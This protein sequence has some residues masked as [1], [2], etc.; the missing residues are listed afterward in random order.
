MQKE[1]VPTK[2]SVLAASFDDKNC[3]SVKGRKG[4][5]IVVGGGDVSGKDVSIGDLTDCRV[6]VLGSPST[7]HAT[8]I[9][10]CTLLCGPVSVL[11]AYLQV[12]SEP[13]IVQRCLKR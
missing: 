11:L 7:L 13:G 5:T 8:G 10:N 1:E 12:K 3:F 6:H 4:E 9:S 2:P